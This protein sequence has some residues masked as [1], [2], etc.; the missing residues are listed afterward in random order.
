MTDCLE[1]PSICPQ[2]AWIERGR[3][4]FWC[5]RRLR[6]PFESYSEYCEEIVDHCD[7]SECP[8]C[9]KDERLPVVRAEQLLLSL[10]SGEQKRQ[11]LTEGEFEFETEGKKWALA[12]DGRTN[13]VLRHVGCITWSNLPMSPP[14]VDLMSQCYLL[15]KKN[16]GMLLSMIDSPTRADVDN[17]A[18]LD[19][20]RAHGAV[21]GEIQMLRRISEAVR[22]EREARLLYYGDMPEQVGRNYWANWYLNTATEAVMREEEI[23]RQGTAPRLQSYFI[24]WLGRYLDAPPG[25]QIQL[26]I[27]EIELV[28]ANRSIYSPRVIVNNKVFELVQAHRE[29]GRRTIVFLFRACGEEIPTAREEG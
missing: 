24:H 4:H 20:C 1:D 13:I 5:V 27:P 26:A 6:Q 2:A 10:L 23:G 29:V 19:W 18:F 15:A 3:H 8:I 9:Q 17:F 11:Y 7:E 16:M 28:G 25:T 22:R 12:L 14:V 21:R